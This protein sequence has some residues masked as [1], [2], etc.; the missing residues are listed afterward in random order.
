MSPMLSE[1]CIAIRRIQRYNIY[2]FILTFVTHMRFRWVAKAK[3]ETERCSVANEE[4]REE[5]IQKTIDAGIQCFISDG[6]DKT[7]LQY[8][9]V[10]AGLSKRSC[11]RYFGNKERFVIAVLKS[12]NVKSYQTGRAYYQK[13]TEQYASAL[14]RLR[15]LMEV[16]GEYFLAHPEVF[17][18]LSEGQSYLQRTASH[19]EIARQYTLLYDYWPSVV[20]S[21]MKQGASEGSITCFPQDY[22]QK[23]E[24]G[25][26]WYAYIGLLVQL[27]Y[28]SSLGNYSKEDCAETIHRFIEQSIQ[29]LN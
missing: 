24:A 6:I 21:L 5:N 20:L 18:L 26:L 3:H 1:P 16:T 14:E 12:I 9:A 25:A 17:M 27:A 7:Q 19:S 11:L 13:I 28:A 2:N 15:A 22:I 23:N 4:I 8:V 29:S 10:K